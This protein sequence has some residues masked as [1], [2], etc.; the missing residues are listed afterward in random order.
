[1]RYDVYF[2]RHF[3]IN[4]HY[5]FDNNEAFFCRDTRPV[6]LELSTWP[7][8]NFDGDPGTC[9]FDAKRREKLE[10]K[11]N[12]EVKENREAI[13]N[14]KEVCCHKFIALLACMCVIY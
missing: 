10:N 1:M 8:L 6:F 7:T 4:S 14:K 12:K 13:A 11:T 3:S 9:P 5:F 2:N